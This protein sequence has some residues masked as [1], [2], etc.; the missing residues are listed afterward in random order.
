ME[1]KNFIL[2]TGGAG[3]IGSHTVLELVNAGYTPVI[4]DDLRNANEVVLEGLKKLLGFEPLHYAIDICNPEALDAI[5][6]AHPITGIIHFAADKAVGE[7][8]K[9]PLKYYHNNIAGLVNVCQTA[10]NNHV[11]NLVFSS[12]CTVYG[13]P[14]ENKEVSEDTP[15]S[16]PNSPYGNTKFIGEQILQDLCRA[17]AQFKVVNLRYFNPVGAHPSGLIGEY[18]IGRPNNLLPFV[19]QTAIGKQ[20]QLIVHG[21]DYPT[22]DGTCIR[23]YIHVCDLAQAHVQALTVMTAW[24]APAWEAINIGTGKGTSVLEVIQAFETETGKTLN[25]A[26]GPRRAGD[27][28]EIFANADKAKSLLNWSAS[29]GIRDAIRD[30]WNWEQKLVEHV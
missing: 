8:V 23:D 10:L 30:A 20:D 27:V 2:V 15:K 13:E 11:F 22:P 18:P 9:H 1:Q 29:F 25:W 7:S 14:K 16:A 21:N 28:I 3:Y 19:T 17:E 6:K 5:F 26:F 12:S 24:Q 4:V